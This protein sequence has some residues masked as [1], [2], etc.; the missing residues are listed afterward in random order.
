MTASTFFERLDAARV[1]HGHSPKEACEKIGVS[2]PTWY[3]WKKGFTEPRQ[4]MREAAE[5]YIGA[6][7][8]TKGE[9]D[10]R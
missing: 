5:R 10:E 6:V 9:P 1:L 4:L 8:S 7:P 3:K 2:L